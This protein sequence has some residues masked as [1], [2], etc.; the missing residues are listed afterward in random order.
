[1]N[2]RG[3]R[4]AH[5]ESSQSRKCNVVLYPVCMFNSH[6]CGREYL[7]TSILNATPNLLMLAYVQRMHIKFIDV[8]SKS[9]GS[10]KV[11]SRKILSYNSAECRSAIRIEGGR[12]KMVCIQHIAVLL[13]LL[14]LTK[15]IRIV[16]CIHLCLSLR[17]NQVSSSG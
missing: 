5:V 13:M 11:L 16:V 17:E 4:I 2:L 6:P 10:T 8:L 3:I 15:L 1:M 14:K 12:E 9:S 7:F